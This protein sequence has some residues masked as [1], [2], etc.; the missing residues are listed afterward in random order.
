M[1]EGL[2]ITYQVSSGNIL[3]MYLLIILFESRSAMADVSVFSWITWCL[4]EGHHRLTSYYS[5]VSLVSNIHVTRHCVISHWYSNY[6]YVNNRSLTTGFTCHEFAECYYF[7]SFIHRWD[8]LSYISWRK[9]PLRGLPVFLLRGDWK[10]F[11]LQKCRPPHF[12]QLMVHA[13]FFPRL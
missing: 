8:T 12:A 2:P 1:T 10:N 7:L 11:L 5:S 13:G 3:T 9:H 4:E 6:N